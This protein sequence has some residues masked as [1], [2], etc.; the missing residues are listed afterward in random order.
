M[1]CYYLYITIIIIIVVVVV[2]G[3]SSCV[4]IEINTEEN[5]IQNGNQFECNCNFALGALNI[6][7]SFTPNIEYYIKASD[8]GCDCSVAIIL[9]SDSWPSYSMI[10]N[11]M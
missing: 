3:S 11:T 2:V 1:V 8:Q 4:D 5:T 10:N 6:D 7:Q 9:V